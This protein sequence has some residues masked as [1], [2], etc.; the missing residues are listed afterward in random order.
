MRAVSTDEGSNPRFTRCSRQKLWTRSPAPTSSTSASANSPTTSRLR[1][2]AALAATDADGVDS[3]ITCCRS[4]CDPWIAGA[5]PK[6]TPVSSES[7]AVKPSTLASTVTPFSRGRLAG[8]SCTSASTPHTA[9]SRPRGATDGGE[10]DALSE[11]LPY[12]PAPAGAERTTDGDL[13][14]PDRRSREQQVGDVGTRDQQ[15]EP[16]RAQER[17]QGRAH[18][19]D[20]VVVQWDDAKRPAGRR[21]VVGAVLTPQGGS[22]RIDARLR[23]CRRDASSQAADSTLQHIGATDWLQRERRR[24]PARGRPDLDVGFGAAARMPK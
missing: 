20:Q 5:S 24:E 11:Q 19:A 16:D 9:I 10:R 1:R 6:S 17:Q 3:R 22:Q 21:R 23:D 15:H 8:Q 7:A 2:R 12:E 13:A 4:T 18:V 14:L